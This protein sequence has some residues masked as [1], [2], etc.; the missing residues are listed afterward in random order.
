MP[1]G[2]AL[3]PTYTGKTMAALIEYCTGPGKGRR[4]LFWNTYNS[5][6]TSILAHDPREQPLPEEINNWL[7]RDDTGL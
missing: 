3:E 2:I 5:Q 4:V 7:G 6:D 1:E